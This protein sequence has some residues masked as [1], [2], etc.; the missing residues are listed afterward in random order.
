MLNIFLCDNDPQ[1]LNIVKE[2]VAQE[3]K[4]NNY[5]MRIVFAGPDP[6]ELLKYAEELNGHSNLYFLDIEL[7]ADI[8]GIELA[9][10][11][12]KFDPRAYIVMVT[13]YAD[14]MPITFSYMIEPLAYILKDNSPKMAVQIGSALRLTLERQNQT[15]YIEENGCLFTVNTKARTIALN[16]NDLYYITTSSTPHILEICS[17]K[18]M[19][20]A[21]GTI[22]ECIE[23]LPKNFI[24]I[25]RE[26]IINTDY[27][28]LFDPIDKSVTMVNDSYFQVST[29]Q[30]KELKKLGLHLLVT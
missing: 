11:I 1:Q 16:S 21:R 29:R 5:A 22:N 20:Q 8:N 15:K 12:R 18:T 4:K 19:T 3:I 7:E 25:S 9:H 2:S 6:K 26:T 10:R 14:Y 28:K 13:A 27:V 23:R 24:K 17:K 30:S